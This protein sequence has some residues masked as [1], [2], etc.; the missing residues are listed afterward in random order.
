MVMP[1]L[2]A[3]PFAAKMVNNAMK[4]YHLTMRFRGASISANSDISPNAESV[5]RRNNIYDYDNRNLLI[6]T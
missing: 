2:P 3:L 5:N 1:P 6:D 4:F